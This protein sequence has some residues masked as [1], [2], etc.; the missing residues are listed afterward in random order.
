MYK[1]LM[2]KIQRSNRKNKKYMVKVGNDTIHFGDPNLR[3]K[4]N[5]PQRKEAFDKRFNCSNPGPKTKARF[6][7]CEA[8]KP[9]TEL[10]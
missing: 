6:W 5:N 2:G 9:D 8:W 7:A 1:V 4:R 3:I 10:P